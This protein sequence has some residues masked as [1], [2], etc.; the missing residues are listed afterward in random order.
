MDIFF[1]K[2]QGGGNDFVIID[3]RTNMEQLKDG[4]EAAK[5]LCHRKFGIGADGLIL[6]EN[7]TATH[8]TTHFRWRF[9]NADGS[10]AEMCGNGARCAARFAHLS[11]I[12]PAQ[13]R[14]E[15][16]A[17]II[18]AEI[19]DD[20]EQVRIRLSNPKNL[21]T[22]ISLPLQQHN[23]TVHHINTG[24]PHTIMFVPDI[25]QAPVV[26][27]GRTIRYHEAFQ[28][29][30]TNVNF[31]QVLN[32]FEISIRTYE[33]GVEDETLACGTGATA[34]AIISAVKGLCRPPVKVQTRGGDVLT[35]DFR[36][37]AEGVRDVFLTGP[38]VVVFTGRI[39]L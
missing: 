25:G 23:V 20:S 24:V 13:M 12:A 26:E 18:E 36:L 11:R 39:T 5:R 37:N 21:E 34:S 10:E 30:G 29:K 28:P 19:C 9:F 33:R 31:V 17:G 8:T 14:F 1:T 22:D 16:L 32:P 15:T 35:I 4:K 3:N 7:P 38:A 2:M 27:S 6:I